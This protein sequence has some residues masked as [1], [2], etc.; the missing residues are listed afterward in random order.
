VFVA[1]P[2]NECHRFIYRNS[3][4]YNHCCAIQNEFARTIQIDIYDAAYQIFHRTIQAP[5][6]SIE[7]RELVQIIKATTNLKPSI[8]NN[9]DSNCDPDGAATKLLPLKHFLLSLDSDSDEIVDIVALPAQI[10]VR[11]PA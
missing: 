1:A 9:K 3:N 6:K 2:L 10:E 4:D 11:T 7:S 5:T 8:W